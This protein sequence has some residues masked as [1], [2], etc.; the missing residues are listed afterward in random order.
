MASLI[1]ALDLRGLIAC[2]KCFTYQ[3]DKYRLIFIH[4]DLNEEERC[5]VLAHEEGHI[6]NRHFSERRIFGNDIIQEYEANE[7]VYHLLADR[8]AQ[9]RKRRMFVAVCTGFC[10]FLSVCSIC[11]ILKK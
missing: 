2:S 11:V 10:L 3:N 7:F 9:R 5:I 6:W 1:E 4:E 8:E